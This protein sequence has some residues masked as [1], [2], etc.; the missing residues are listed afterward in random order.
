MSVTSI[1]KNK[2]TTI[3]EDFNSTHTPW[4]GLGDTETKSLQNINICFLE[5]F[6]RYQK[7]NPI[8]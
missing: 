5:K 6:V 4:V 7:K 3:M 1:F 8:F 2:N